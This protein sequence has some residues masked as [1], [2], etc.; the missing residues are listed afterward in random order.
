LFFQGT[1]QSELKSNPKQL[2]TNLFLKF[3]LL[4]NREISQ[5]LLLRQVLGWAAELFLL[6]RFSY[7]SGGMLSHLT[8]VC[9]LLV[10]WLRPAWFY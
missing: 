9:L 3:W 7:H 2:K 1:D 4:L 5:N 6:A 10:S 8:N